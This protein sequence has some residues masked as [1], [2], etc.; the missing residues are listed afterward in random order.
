MLQHLGCE[1]HCVQGPAQVMA[2]H[3]EEYA[4]P[5][6]GLGR[7]NRHGLRHGLVNGLIEAQRIV[8]HL[9][10][11]LVRIP[12]E[13]QHSGPEHPVLRHELFGAQAAARA[14][15]TMG[16][17]RRLGSECRSMSFRLCD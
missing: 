15:L 5:A 11:R 14:Q 2:Q 16:L 13:A 12:P 3:S 10:V 17:R 1:Q 4:A 6:L 8:E 9:C 7:V